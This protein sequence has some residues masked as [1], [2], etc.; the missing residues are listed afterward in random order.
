MSVMSRSAILTL[1]VLGACNAAQDPNHSPKAGWSLQASREWSAKQYYSYIFIKIAA[2]SEPASYRL[3]ISDN[4]VNGFHSVALIYRNTKLMKI[5]A[6]G[7]S[8]TTTL[9]LPST[10]GT[11][12]GNLALAIAFDRSA[13][14]MSSTGGTVRFS[15]ATGA[16]W[17]NLSYERPVSGTSIGALNIFRSTKSFAADT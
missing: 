4:A 11:A 3:P 1:L 12:A 5:G 10:S 14:A 9:T 13:A 16:D 15:S 6:S 8:K 7:E 2:A 17:S